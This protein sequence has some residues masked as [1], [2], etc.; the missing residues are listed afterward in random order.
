MGAKKKRKD[1][2]NA[3]IDAKIIPYPLTYDIIKKLKAE[4]N[5]Y[6]I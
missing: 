2:V 6:E 1:Y 3:N 5:N 4:G